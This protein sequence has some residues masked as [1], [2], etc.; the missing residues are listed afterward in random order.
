MW[1]YWNWTGQLETDD[2]LEE[3]IVQIPFMFILFPGLGS[4]L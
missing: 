1:V 3:K 4:F 2:F